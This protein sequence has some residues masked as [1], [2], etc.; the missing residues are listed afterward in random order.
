MVTIWYDDRTTTTMKIGILTQPLQYNYGGLLQNYALQ[1]VLKEAGNECVTL[2]WQNIYIEPSATK[3][4]K[5]VAVLKH[6]IKYLLNKYPA[7]SKTSFDSF[8]DNHIDSTPKIFTSRGFAKAVRELEIDAI[9]V[10][11]DQCWRPIYC[12]PFLK[13]MFACFASSNI[14][15]YAYAASFGTDKWEYSESEAKIASKLLKEFE[16]V[17]VRESSAIDLCKTHLGV[18]A[19]QVLDPTMLL[20]S[21]QYAAIVEQAHTPISPGN[22]YYYILDSTPE[23]ATMLN[24]ISKEYNLQPYYVERIQQRRDSYVGKSVEPSVLSWIRGFMDAKMVIVDSFH[25][26]VFSIIFNK[27]FWVIANKERGVARFESL[28]KLFGLEN[29]IITDY[30]TVDLK[31]DIDWSS[32]NKMLYQLRIISKNFLLSNLAH[33]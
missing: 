4:R 5:R 14:K 20:T 18:E 21:E 24:S 8:K 22:F 2:D 27:P 15:K 29:R 33:E 19:T 17:S 31:K 26:M 11:S 1:T 28:L 7:P 9:V 16:F 6:Y 3:F 12:F 23:K 13:Q 30:Q 32:V 25:G 10:G